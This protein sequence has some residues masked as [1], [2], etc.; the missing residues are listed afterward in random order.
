M[1][2]DSSLLNLPIG[3][4]LTDEELDANRRDATADLLAH[5]L[6]GRFYRARSADLPKITVPLLSAANW[7]HGLHSRGGFEGWAQASSVQKWLEVHGLGH[8]TEFY[9]A[10]GLELQRRFF[11]HFLKGEDT[12]WDR[13]PPVQLNVRHVDGGFEQRAEREWP[14]A[15][16]EWT[17]SYLDPGDGSLTTELF[18]EP[19][20]I[21]GPAAARLVVASSTTD[22]DLFLTVRV[23]DPAGV[24][25]HGWLRASHRALDAERSRRTTP[26]T[27]TTAST[28]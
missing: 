21:T 23:L 6:N 1:D 9:T 22:A 27:R 15:R 7:A 5:P 12:G 16:T 17:R 20:E 14:L 2:R 24:V 26:G 13:Q 11:G 25:A 28:R 10:H 19:T 3:Q 4:P 18:A 8:V